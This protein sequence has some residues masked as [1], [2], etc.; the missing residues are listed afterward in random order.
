VLFAVCAI[1]QDSSPNQQ[2]ANPQ[3]THSNQPL[4]RPRQPRKAPLQEFYAQGDSDWLDTGID[5]AP[6]EH[7][8][9]TA[10]GTMRYVGAK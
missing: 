4:P 6:G 9:A 2:L 5:V 10:K 8:V 3:T 1:A 7:V